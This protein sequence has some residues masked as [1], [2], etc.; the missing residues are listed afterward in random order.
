MKKILITGSSGFLGKALCK[1][2]EKNYEL[3]K[4]TSSNCDLTTRNIFNL[5][6]VRYDYIIHCAVKTA[7]GGY[8]QQH[9]GEQFLMNSIINTNILTY[10]KECQQQAKFITF[11][12]SCA[13]DDN[14]MKIETNYLLGKC[15]TGF[16]TY[17]MIKRMLY[18]GLKSLNQE[19]GM[20]YLYFIPSTFYGEDY[21]LNDKHFIFDIIR[22]IYIAKNDETKI[23]VLHGTGEQRRDLI[24]CKDAINII[25]NSM[26]NS[27]NE[28]INLTTGKNHSIKEYAKI[29]CEILKYDY[30]KITFD[31]TQFVGMLDKNL[32][33]TKLKNYKFTDITI[34]I[35]NTINYLKT[36]I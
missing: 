35:E 1:R 24:Y 20:D 28:I 9:P 22:K 17:G 3:H 15:E 32:I 23:V 8:C 7:A 10:W 4:I 30:N 27:K 16:E 36:Q 19:Y 14:I 31:D 12:S 26:V 21:H 5:P 2:L 13:Y 6:Y 18:I 33:N 25:E 29:I 34:G 11:G